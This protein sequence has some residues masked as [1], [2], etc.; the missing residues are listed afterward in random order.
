MLWLAV[1]A[2]ALVA[3]QIQAQSLRTLSGS[4][5][6][7]VAELTSTR[8]FLRGPAS[9]PRPYHEADDALSTISQTARLRDHGQV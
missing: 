8:Y 7:L 5:P 4:L 6:E 3:P 9:D 2:V 1:L